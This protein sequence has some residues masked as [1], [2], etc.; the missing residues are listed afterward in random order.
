MDEN[1]DR[2]LRLLEE[3][4][5]T[6]EQAE[7]LI[8]ALHEKAPPPPP[9]GNGQRKEETAADTA[10]ARAESGPTRS[11]EFQW[12]QKHTFPFDLGGIGK[13]IAETMRKID[14]ERILQEVRQNIERESKRWQER[15]R[16][17]SR[18]ADGEEGRPENP[19]GHPTARAHETLRFDLPPDATIQ[20]ENYAG[21]VAV[22]G[23]GEH[24][25]VEVEK[26]AWAS[27]SAEAEQRLQ[28]MKVE[29]MIHSSVG[30]WPPPPPPPPPFPGPPKPGETPPPTPPPPEPPPHPTTT[31][32]ISRLE[33]RVSMP[34]GWRDGTVN[35]R[36]HVPDTVRLRLNSSFGEVRVEN[37][38]GPVEVHTASGDI[39]LE[40][41]RSNVQAESASGEIRA[42]DIAGKLKLSSRS[43]DLHVEQLA[44]GGEITG[45]SGEVH[46]EGVEGGRLEAKSVSGDLH[47]RDAGRQN[48]IEIVAETRSGDIEL[49]RAQG[50]MVLKTVSGD[51]TAERVHATTL[52]AQTS[53]GDLKI[54]LDS[55]LTGTLSASTVSGD[56]EIRTPEGGSFRFTLMTQVG[57]LH[58][59]LAVQDSHHTETLWT[60]TVGAGEGTVNVQSMSGDIRLRQR[61]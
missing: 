30:A 21:D 27:T 45:E 56:A 49:E 20:V 34:E 25:V 42:K 28:D 37:T 38:A 44:Q 13:Q 23:G 32:G 24:V 10:S 60:G 18:M 59:N 12:S 51:I 11:F 7:R 47:I 17:W 48:P 29:A 61:E 9:P 4:K 43:G 31:E 16:A 54:E 8:S 52:Q 58:C 14:P 2:I 15:M 6:A 41:L 36:L 46:I 35:L 33:I 1:I 5:I 53:S 55:P 50:S 19:L 3:G 57:E 26:E 39:A 22:F 40:H